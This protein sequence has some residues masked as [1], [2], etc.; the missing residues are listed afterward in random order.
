MSRVMTLEEIGRKYG[1]DKVDHLYLPHYER[2]FSSIRE[3]EDVSILEIGVMDGKSL[4]MWKEYFFS[5]KIY[6]IDVK[7]SSCFSED[8]IECFCGRQQDERFLLNVVEKTG[9]LD[10]VID[11]GSHRG[12]DHVASFKVLWPKVKPGGWYCIEDCQSLFNNCWT[13]PEDYTIL[14]WLQENWEPL[15]RGRGN[16]AEVHVIGDG[17]NDGLICLKKKN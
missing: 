12:K 3:L 15:L 14:D 16:I 8:R 17:I 6:G 10:V 2:R 4:R 5:G 9:L 13:Q 11:D 7:P 1:T